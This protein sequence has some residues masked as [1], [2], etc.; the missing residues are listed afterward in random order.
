MYHTFY[1]PAEAG[2]YY[3]V[4][5]AATEEEARTAISSVK[6]DPPINECKQVSQYDDEE[7]G[8]LDISPE[9]HDSLDKDG[10]AC[11]YSPT[12]K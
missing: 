12:K 5:R 7:F 11:K 9:M 8:A 10:I 3:V 4:A 2:H 6:V 1:C